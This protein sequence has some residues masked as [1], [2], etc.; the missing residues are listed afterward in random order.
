MA[1]GDETYKSRVSTQK[2]RVDEVP[3]RSETAISLDGYPLMILDHIVAQ[4]VR[5]HEILDIPQNP[6]LDV[7]LRRDSA[8]AARRPCKDV[9][10]TYQYEYCFEIIAAAENRRTRTVSFD[11]QYK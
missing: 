1:Q 9:V 5:G 6:I 4:D 11:V 7:D 8:P 10:T 3:W 2:G